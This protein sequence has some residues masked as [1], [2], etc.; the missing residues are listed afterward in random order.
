MEC[1]DNS[2]V[3][4]THLFTT[5][6]T[7]NNWAGNHVSYPS[8]VTV[9]NEV[10]LYYCGDGPSTYEHRIGMMKRSNN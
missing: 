2:P 1:R 6:S 10:R 3:S 8:V 9:N 5:S 4:Y 7:Y